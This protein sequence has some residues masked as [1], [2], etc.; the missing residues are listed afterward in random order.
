[1][2]FQRRRRWSLEDSRIECVYDCLASCMLTVRVV[3]L[4]YSQLLITWSFEALKMYCVIRA[5]APSLQNVYR[6]YGLHELS[7]NRPRTI[8]SRYYAQG[9]GS[10][11]S[12][13]IPVL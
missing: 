9:L 13:P 6:C 8:I 7:E 10:E 3:A 1:M 2:P 4:E 11:A 5:S 12:I